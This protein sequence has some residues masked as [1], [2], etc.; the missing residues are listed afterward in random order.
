[1]AQLSVIVTTYNVADYVDQALTSLERQTLADIEIIV[2]DDGSTDS[3]VAIIQEHAGRD[4]RIVPI[5]RRQNSIGGVATSANAGLDAATSDYVGFLDGDDYCEPTMFEK[6]LEAATT[7]DT[8]LAMCQYRLLDEVTGKLAWPADQ[9]RWN[10]L[11]PGV[12]TLD[13]QARE[14]LLSFVA[15]P[16]RKLYR[17]ELLE[18]NQ[19]RFPVGDYFYEDNPFHWFCILKAKSIA[20]V[21]EVLCYHRVS[22][23][24]QTMNTADERLF[25]MFAHH[26]T[27]HAWLRREGMDLQ[28]SGALIRWVTSQLEWIS[29]RTPPRLRRELVDAAGRALAPYSVDQVESA[30]AKRGKGPRARALAANVMAGNVAGVSLILDRWGESPNHVVT[31]RYYLRYAGVRD[32]FQRAQGFVARRGRPP[33]E[34]DPAESLQIR[35]TFSNRDL[36]FALVLLES[37]LDSITAR[38]DEQQARIASSAIPGDSG[39]DRHVPGNDV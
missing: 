27:I 33:Q 24:G 8:D 18:S 11:E 21:P 31:A 17:R 23:V 14:N 5:L 38:L 20:I 7:H 28:Y 13:D 9:Q 30:L 12:L 26:D 15:V 36:M 25:K 4:A 6:L 19:I 16:W 10:S 37:R 39:D 1:M 3:T 34:V 22:R 2:V 29:A 35:P 32:T